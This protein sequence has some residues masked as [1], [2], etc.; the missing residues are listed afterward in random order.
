MRRGEARVTSVKMG[1]PP[2]DA[3]A[4][5]GDGTPLDVVVEVEATL[6]SGGASVTATAKDIL[7][8]GRREGQG[9]GGS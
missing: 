6:V 5:V 8:V 7:Q 9:G 1:P 3:P 2:A 4:L